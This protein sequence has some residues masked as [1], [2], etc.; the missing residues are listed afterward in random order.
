MAT[1]ALCDREH[2]RQLK[3]VLLFSPSVSSSCERHEEVC[4]HWNTTDSVS[5]FTFSG[6]CFGE[7][8]LVQHAALSPPSVS[9]R[10]IKVP[11]STC[12]RRAKSS[13]QKVFLTRLI[14]HS[15]VGLR[16][17]TTWL[18]SGKCNQFYGWW[19]RRNEGERKDQGRHSLRLT[20][21][22][23]S[24]AHLSKNQAQVTEPS[25][26]YRKYDSC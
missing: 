26:G 22:G 1:A 3:F 24:T 12:V 8:D 14:G 7:C 17:K 11:F 9:Y 19:G 13:C 25:S 5:R 10:H 15:L 20:D 18:R 4:S 16:T 6:G 2:W 23:K 21:K